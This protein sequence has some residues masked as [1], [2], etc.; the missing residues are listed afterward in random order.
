MKRIISIFVIILL[1]GLYISSFVLALTGNPNTQRLLMLSIGSTIFVPVFLYIYLRIWK[2]IT[3][4][5][6]NDD[7]LI[8]FDNKANT[9]IPNEDS[10][11]SDKELE[12]ESINYNKEN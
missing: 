2:N 1:L 9:T 5:N 6:I 7:S 12:E 10:G 3:K 4:G 11:I 8:K